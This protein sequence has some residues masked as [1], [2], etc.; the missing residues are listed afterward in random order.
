M[1][2]Q[3]LLGDIV[4]ALSDMGY[5]AMNSSVRAQYILKICET[6]EQV[7]KHLNQE[8]QVRGIV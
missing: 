8:G 5:G 2:K 6:E 3:E 4:K 7:L 1:N